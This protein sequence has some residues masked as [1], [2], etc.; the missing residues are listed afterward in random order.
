MKREVVEEDR[1]NG[2]NATYVTRPAG[3]LASVSYGID[4]LSARH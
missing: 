4:S 2:D 1:S 3:R